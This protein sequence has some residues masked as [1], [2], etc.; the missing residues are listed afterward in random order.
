MRRSFGTE[1]SGNR[2]PRVELLDMQRAAILSAVEAGEKKTK[3]AARYRVS[4]RVIYSTLNQW[5]NHHTLKSLLR[6]GQP[7]KL[8]QR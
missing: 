3:I 5:N 2:G 8:T 6:S 7:K 4:R 1:I